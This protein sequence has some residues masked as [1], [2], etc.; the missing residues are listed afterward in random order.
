[1]KKR[2]LFVFLLSCITICLFVPLHLYAEGKKELSNG[3]KIY[4]PVY[5]HIYIGNKEKPFLLTVTL[6]IRNTDPN[7]SIKIIVVD[8]YHTQ[9]NRLEKYLDKSV[10]LNPLGSL[11]YII[12]EKDKT[13]GSGANFIVEWKSDKYVNP[14]IVETIMIGTYTQ[15]GI[16]FTSRG[17]VIFTSN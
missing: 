3:Q 17:Q 7:N 9:G 14:P 15:Q 12:P 8:Y 11:R 2:H 1:M 13:G 6:S 10:I 5:S 4:V 16:S